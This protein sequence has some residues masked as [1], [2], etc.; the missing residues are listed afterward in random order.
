MTLK[1]E[2]KWARTKAM[3]DTK[4]EPHRPEIV[5]VIPVEALREWL[6]SKQS[7]W[8]TEMDVVYNKAI[9]DLLAELEA[10]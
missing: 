9:D 2:V 1:D 10:L 5:R 3:W 6:E 8:A 4:F 7:V